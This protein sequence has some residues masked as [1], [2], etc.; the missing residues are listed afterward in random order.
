[1]SSFFANQ[2]FL[3]D[4]IVHLSPQEAF[5]AIG[6]G[7]VLVDL[8]DD[9]EISLK[10]FDVG[11]ILY[12]SNVSGDEPKISLSKLSRKAPLILA[13]SVGLRSK[14]AAIFLKKQGYDVANLIGGIVEWQRD[15]LPMQIDGF[16]TGSCAC[17]LRPRKT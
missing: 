6:R 1:M 12:I 5:L 14:E 8:R 11:N 15:G 16:L 13:D 3:I 9:Q 4:T 7:A 17:R 10:R 2:G